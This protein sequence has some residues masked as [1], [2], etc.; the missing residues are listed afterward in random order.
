MYTQNIAKQMID[1]QKTTFD[2]S[3][4]AFAMIQ[5]Q[6]ERMFDSAMDQ[7]SWL[8]KESKRAIDEWVK[9]CRSGRADFKSIVDENFDK[10]AG[11]LAAEKPVPTPP[12]PKTVSSKK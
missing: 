8:P 2:N 3:F 7:A 6:T 10:L 12:A 4:N 9:L 5:D 11:M 1:F